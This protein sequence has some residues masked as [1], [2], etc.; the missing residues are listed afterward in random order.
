MTLNMKAIPMPKDGAQ[1]AMLNK[2]IF[3]DSLT[4]ATWYDVR[5]K[6]YADIFQITPLWDMLNTKGR[7][8]QRAPKGSYFEIPIAYKKLKQNQKF[9]G[10]GAEF[11]R[12]EGEFMTRLQ[13]HVKNFGDSITRY[14]NDEVQN[15]GEA[16]ILDYVDEVITNHK[17]SIEETLHESLWEQGGP[18]AIHSLPELISTTP[19]TGTIAGIDRS[20]NTYVR[21]VAT[22]FTGTIAA[23]LIPKMETMY[24]D[25]SKLKGSA[26][27]TPDIIITTQELYEQYVGIAR[28]LGQY[29]INPAQSGENKVNLGMG[30]AMFKSAEMFWDPNCPDGQM[31]FLNTDTLELPYD[32]NWWMQMTEWKGEP[33]SLERFAQVVTRCNLVCNNFNKNG[34]MYDIA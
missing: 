31:Y 28:A 24:N 32:P 15:V 27:L 8:K 5:K 20:K 13:Y 9:F 10:R 29:Q 2:Q 11:S 3:V 4:T 1:D 17:S 23:D 18:L 34:V 7:I 26:R 22:A 12:E 33:T 30:D 6:L 19:T 14:W 16:Q 21:N 25:L